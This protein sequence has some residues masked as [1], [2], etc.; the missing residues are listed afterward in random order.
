MQLVKA[1]QANTV[2][3]PMAAKATGGPITSGAV[4]FYLIDR[5]TGKWFRGSDGTWQVAESIAGA[6]THLADGHWDLDLPSAA[7]TA[8]RR[9]VSLPPAA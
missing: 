5:A 2:S 1:S 3:L 8:G 9:R 4:N 7:W 6:A